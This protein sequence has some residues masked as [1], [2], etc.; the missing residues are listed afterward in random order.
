[1]KI[2]DRLSTYMSLLGNDFKTA[3][4]PGD[5][6]GNAP[7]PTEATHV[8]VDIS[9]TASQLAEDEA[10][11]ERLNTIRQQLTAGSYNIS[12]KN[13]ADKILGLLKP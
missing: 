6:D 10:R 12:G 7:A 11:R 8:A 1:M 2:D 3:A 4:R 13:V 5:T 9:P